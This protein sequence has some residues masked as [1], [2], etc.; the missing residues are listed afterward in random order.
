MKNQYK[1]I[2]LLGRSDKFVQAILALFED[3]ELV[4]VPWRACM[5]FDLDA[6]DILLEINQ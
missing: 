4:V 5:D 3:A 2:I 1:R 6:F